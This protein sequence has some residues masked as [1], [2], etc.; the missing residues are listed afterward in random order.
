VAVRNHCTSHHPRTCV[1]RKSICPGSMY[2]ELDRIRVPT[3]I[4]VGDLD[5]ATPPAKAAR[6]AARIPGAWLVTI[7]GAGHTATVEEPEAVNRELA[8]FLDDRTGV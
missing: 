2:D 3:L 1:P 8:A 5:V 7:P 6:I 4:M